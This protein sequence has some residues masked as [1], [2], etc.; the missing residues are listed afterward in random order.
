VAVVPIGGG[1]VA[2]EE[3]PDVVGD[4]APTYPPHPLV[5]VTWRDAWF[6]LDDADPEEAR[7]DYLVH[8]VGFLARE[9]PRFVSIAQEILPDGDGF[10][11]VTH[12]PV[13]VVM[14]IVTLHER[15]EDEIA[16]L[17]AP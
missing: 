4:G 6:D 1:D 2:R 3:R 12:I 11:A 16:E 7:A 13:S 14:R 10:R 5:L 15:P 17:P 9:G 8:T